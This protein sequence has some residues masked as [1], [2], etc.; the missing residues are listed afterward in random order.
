MYTLAIIKLIIV[1]GVFYKVAAD[2][3]DL[4]KNISKIKVTYPHRILFGLHA[5][6]LLIIRSSSMAIGLLFHEVGIDRFL[7]GDLW[8]SLYLSNFHAISFSRI[9][10]TFFI[11]W[12]NLC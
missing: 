4:E 7:R 8:V 10:T 12:Y 2:K 11:L 3:L 6:S 9:Q 1:P 5:P